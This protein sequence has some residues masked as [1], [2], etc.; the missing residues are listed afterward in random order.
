MTLWDDVEKTI[1]AHVP[2]DDLQTALGNAGFLFEKASGRG[3]DPV[4]PK[5]VVATAV[6]LSSRQRVRDALVAFVT[7]CPDDVN[8]KSAYWA[9]GKLEDSSLRST[10]VAGLQYYLDRD[11]ELL[12]QVLVA[13]SSIERGVFGESGGGSGERDYERNR[14]L[15]RDYLART[16]KI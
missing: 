3:T 11:P 14:R 12:F 7:R 4:W 10:F 16:E 5:E 6:D 1:L 8:C 2:H 13:F 9:L 15:A